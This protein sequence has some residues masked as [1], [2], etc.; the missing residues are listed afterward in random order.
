MRKM[1][2]SGVKWMGEIPETWQ[3]TKYKYF[4]QSRMGETILAADLKTIGIN[5]MVLPF[6]KSQLNS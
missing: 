2:D 6:L 5:M 3:V 4:S 1:K